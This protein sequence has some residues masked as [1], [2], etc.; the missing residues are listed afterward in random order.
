MSGKDH[1]YTAVFDQ[2][3]ITMTVI[4]QNWNGTELQRKTYY[5]SGTEPSYSGS[6]PTRPDDNYRYTFSGWTLLSSS[7]PYT[8]IY[9]A[10]YTSV[11]K[12]TVT[13][14]NW[15]NSVLQ[16]KQY[17]GGDPEPSYDGNTPTRADTIPSS[18][19]GT[20]YTFSGW[21]LISS[22]NFSKE[23]QAQFSTQVLYI[24][25]RYRVS[26]TSTSKSAS[27]FGFTGLQTVTKSGSA[28]NI[29]VTKYY[30]NYSGQT[31]YNG[32]TY[33]Y[34][35]GVRDFNSSRLLFDDETIVVPTV[36]NGNMGYS[37]KYY[38]IPGTGQLWGEGANRETATGTYLRD[39]NLQTG[40]QDF[41]QYTLTTSRGAYVDYITSFSLS[42][43]PSNGISG[44]YWYVRR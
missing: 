3:E 37:K 19:T 17:F 15:D 25:D 35:S 13:W 11:S 20:R 39:Y 30:G 23:Y 2:N 38:R 12:I 8:V 42:S 40:S 31:T 18:G 22:S 21:N 44:S 16:T 28:G 9:Q 7:D 29:T 6:T 26:N 14:K 4:W 32:T 34:T 1:T 5:K 27:H 10:Q 43:Y 33:Y 36:K 41:I 24:W